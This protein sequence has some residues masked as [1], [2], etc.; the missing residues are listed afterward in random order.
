MKQ[1]KIKGKL[2]IGLFAMVD[3]ED[4]EYL[5]QFNWFNAHGYA[6][7][8]NWDNST[9]THRSILMHREVMNFPDL[10]GIDHKDHNKL[11]NQKNNLRTSTQSENLKNKTSTQKSASKYL[12]VAINNR[13]PKYW[14][15]KIK[16]N[17]KGK[18][19]GNYPY[20]PQGEI[21]AALKYNEFAKVYHGEFAN[22]NIVE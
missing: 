22:L 10:L 1:I 13:H 18:H 5:N 4:F 8:N 9:K 19:L 11:N 2:G 16:V 21:L 15:A 12:G 17:G 3:D 6:R 7:R 14:T 20:T